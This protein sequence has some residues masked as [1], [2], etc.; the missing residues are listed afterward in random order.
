M[1]PPY[2]L[3]LLDYFLHLPLRPAA[4]GHWSGPLRRPFFR[5]RVRFP[6]VLGGGAPVAA[7][8]GIPAGVPPGENLAE[9]PRFPEELGGKAVPSEHLGGVD[10][11]IAGW[12]K[13]GCGFH[14]G[15]PA[16]PS[17][18]AGAAPPRAPPCG[19]RAR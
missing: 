13:R 16:N 11:T 8:I 9:G 10:G 3:A 14:C 2:M 12:G 4:A 15:W 1:P 6:R 17:C 5:G 7:K 19:R 18:C